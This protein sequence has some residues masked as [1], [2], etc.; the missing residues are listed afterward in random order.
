MN[1][2]QP[3]GQKSQFQHV[4]SELL[5]SI[6]RGFKIGLSKQIKTSIWQRNDQK[7]MIRSQ[8]SYQ[9]ISE[10]ILNNPLKWKENKFFTN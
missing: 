4:I 5:S 2:D 7:Y 1:E 6:I 10:Y 8:E 9:K 3:L